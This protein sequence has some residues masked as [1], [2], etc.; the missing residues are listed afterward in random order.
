MNIMSYDFHGDWEQTVNHN[1][2]LFSLNSASTY[3]KKLTVVSLQ[4]YFSFQI[5]LQNKCFSFEIK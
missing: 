2:P 1:S 5:T 4:L 3:Q